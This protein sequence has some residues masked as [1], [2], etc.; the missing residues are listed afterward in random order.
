MKRNRSSPL[1]FRRRKR[2]GWGKGIQGL[3]ARRPGPAARPGRPCSRSTAIA[4]I[5]ALSVQSAQRGDVQLDA[6]RRGLLLQPLRGAG[7]LAATPPPTQ[8]IR[9][10][11]CSQRG[12]GL[13]HQA[14]DH[15]LLE[16]GGQVGHLLRASWIC[17][18]SGRPGPAIAVADR[19]LQAAEAEIQPL[20]VVGGRPAA[21]R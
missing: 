4:P 5:T 21:R 7:A 8:R 20:V 2:L 19:R 11:V 13:V 18:K 14:V 17:E 16:A 9:S 1:H 15:G 6:A 12:K 10:P 3:R